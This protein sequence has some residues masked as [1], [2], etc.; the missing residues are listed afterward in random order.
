MSNVA[1]GTS[2]QTRVVAKS[3]AVPALIHLLSSENIDVKVQA[4]WA[5]GN[6]AGEGPYCRDI[7]LQH[8]GLPPLLHLVRHNKEQS[9]LRKATWTLSNLCRKGEYFPNWDKV[10]ETFAQ[11]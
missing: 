9:L 3:G 2:E 8:N 10:I 6:I 11:V 5:L 1:A 4:V 7:V